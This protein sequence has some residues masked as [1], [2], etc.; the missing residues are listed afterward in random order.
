M[1]SRNATTVGDWDEADLRDWE[2]AGYEIDEGQPAIARNGLFQRV[3]T[4]RPM[5]Y[6]LAAGLIVATA[7][8]ILTRPDASVAT[9]T[10]TPTAAPATPA[11]MTYDAGPVI[12]PENNKP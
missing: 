12:D 9:A 4:G 6:I 5:V 3:W 8:V 7:L 11:L 1:S 10:A 2:D